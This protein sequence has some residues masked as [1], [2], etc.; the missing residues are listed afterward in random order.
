MDRYSAEIG[1]CQGCFSS[2]YKALD[3]ENGEI[4][5]V[6]KIR[7]A[8]EGMPATALREIS[9]LRELSGSPDIVTLRNAVVCYAED[10]PHAGGSLFLIFEFLPK[11]LQMY[12]HSLPNLGGTPCTMDPMLTRSYMYQLLRGVLH[13]HAQGVLHRDLKPAN[14]LIDETGELKVSGL[15]LARAVALPIRP[16]THEVVTLW[17]RAPEVLLAGPGGH[18]GPPLDIWSVGAILFE[19]ATSRPLFPGDSEI[20]Q[21]FRIFRALGTPTEEAWPGVSALRDFSASFPQFQAKGLAQLVRERGG[22]VAADA[23]SAAGLDLLGQ[24]L[25]FNPAERITARQ[26][27]A[28]P[29]FDDLDGGPGGR[30]AFFEQDGQHGGSIAFMDGAAREP[31][32]PKGETVRALPGVVDEKQT[33]CQPGSQHATQ[34]PMAM[35]QGTVHEP[36]LEY[37]ANAADI[38]QDNIAQAGGGA[39]PAAEADAE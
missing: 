7:W 32:D 26:A 2:V 14:L 4:V 8:E 34:K 17:Y 38:A 35:D 10:D 22:A 11:N 21:L 33:P 29:Y 18:Y 13:C 39:A 28:H 25:R 15:K 30:I 19:M 24:C 12:M 9:L 5:A 6:K 27:L 31:V 20:D 3:K 1:T 16:L 37:G 36:G 23:F